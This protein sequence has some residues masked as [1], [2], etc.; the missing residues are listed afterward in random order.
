MRRS[1][2]IFLLVLLSVSLLTAVATAASTSDY[3]VRVQLSKGISQRE[4][5][6]RGIDVLHVY[7]DGKADLAVTEEQLDWIRA[8]VKGV[9]ILERAS[10]QGVAELDENLGDY[11]TY[12]EMLAEL[13]Q[14][15]NDHPQLARL[16]TIGTSIEGRVIVALKVSDNVDLDEDEPEVLIMGCHHARELMSVEVPIYLARYLL[17]NYS[18]SSQVTEL[19]DEREIW[20]APMINPDGH[21]YVQYNH[22]GDWWTWWRKNRRNNGDG[23]YGVDLNRNYGYMWG[24]D[25]V[26]SSPDPGS[27]V[28]R[29]TGPFSEPETQAVRDF[30]AARQFSVA[31][32]YHSYGELILF[33]WGYAPI[34]TDDHELFV[35]LS[36]SLKRGNDYTPGNTAMGTI[37]VTNGDS[38][39]WAYGDTT[40]KNRIFSLTVELNTYEEGGFAPPE[41]LIAPTFEKVKELNL[42]AI[43]VADDPYRVLGPYP[44]T[45][46]PVTMLNPPN[47][48]ITWSGGVPSDHNQP[49]SWEL[50]EYKNLSG[51]LD[52]CEAGSDLWQLDG[53][54]LSSA[55][56]YDGIYSYYSGS[57]NNLS[58]KLTM[59]TIYS[60]SFSDTVRCRLWYDIEQDWDYAYLEVSLDQGL[61][62]MTVPGNRTTDYDPNGNNRGN[63]IT[64]SSGGWVDAEFYLDSIGASPDDA[65][66]LRFAYIT[67][68]YVANEGLYVDNIF[69][70]STYEKRTVLVSAHPDTVYHRW[71]EETGTFTYYVIAADA[72]GQKS[73][74]SNIVSHVVDDLSGS[75]IPVVNSMLRSNYPNPF[76]P[77]TSISFSVGSRD[78]G[79]DG[80]AHVTLQ[81]FDIS[82]RKVRELVNARM[83]AGE[84]STRWDGKDSSGKTLASGVYFARLKVGRNVMTKKLVLLR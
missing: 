6:S 13:V 55:R 37:Y 84:Y 34:Y 56:A 75:R 44:P 54:S 4:L 32:S 69:P 38:D 60:L 9:R 33:P 52:D 48:E 79:G 3:L 65:V 64:G 47:Y 67:D 43:R 70:V 58:N 59:S 16:D 39:D 5:V 72:D 27:V 19:V 49:V 11:H 21:V 78:L 10:L 57:G 18:T 8:R 14:L 80:L 22:A 62:W 35:A 50:V 74:M 53:F 26:G 81:V 12:D 51:V 66:M 30:C 45:M 46:Y 76:N 61:T 15:E 36:D 82:G 1:T 23:S 73:R 20:I 83:Q 7:P 28:Y 77:S 29:G 63:G 68:S 41:S 25:D 31:L 24:Y 40:A 17:E 2:I 42:T 71:P